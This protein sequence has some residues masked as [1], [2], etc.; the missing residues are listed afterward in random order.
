MQAA[1]HQARRADEVVANAQPF[2]DKAGSDDERLAAQLDQLRAFSEQAADTIRRLRIRVTEL[3]TR[4][5]DAEESVEQKNAYI[6]HLKSEMREDGDT[7]GK[8]QRGASSQS[9]AFEELGVYMQTL[10]SLDGADGTAKTDGLF[11]SAR[12]RS[13][14]EEIDDASSAGAFSPRKQTDSTSQSANEQAKQ[15]E[16]ATWEE[17]LQAEAANTVAREQ[18]VGEREEKL[19]RRE[20]KVQEDELRRLKAKEQ[21]LQWQEARLQRL[22]NLPGQGKDSSS[23]EGSLPIG[24]GERE[25]VSPSCL[26]DSVLETTMVWGRQS[27]PTVQSGESP[28][29]GF[30]LSFRKVTTPFKGPSVCISN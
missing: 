22:L 18:A 23:T 9:Q 28:D 7:I 6:L 27:P 19:R 1:E 17:K 30:D 3:V 4:V 25:T 21:Q 20:V 14:L 8:L 16:L 11:A 13:V 24:G 29:T 10:F 12:G 2:A 5:G 15:S 26:K